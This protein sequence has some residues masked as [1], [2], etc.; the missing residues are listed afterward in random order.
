MIISG[1]SYAWRASCDPAIYTVALGRPDA[2]VMVINGSVL[3]DAP[4]PEMR[5]LN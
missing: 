3:H 1:N 2:P 5:T 4:P